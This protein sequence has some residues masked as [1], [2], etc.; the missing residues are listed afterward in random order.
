MPRDLAEQLLPRVAELWNVYG[1]TETTVWSTVYQVTAVT[2]QIPIGHPIANTQIYILDQHMQP[3]PVGV[4]GELY[5]GG[6]GVS[7][8]YL[9]RPQL[10]SERFIP[11]PFSLDPDAR[12]YKTGDAARYLPDGNIIF[13]GRLDFQ[14]K[15]RGFRIELGEI[16]AA[17]D[18][19]TAV[20]QS[21]V[22]VHEENSSEKR[23][24]AYYI[25]IGDQLPTVSDLRRHIQESLPAYMIPSV[26]I[27][28]DSFPLTPNR[29]V[30]RK[31]L[32][33][34]EQSRPQLEA[35]YV[36]P[37]TEVENIVAEA[38][39]NLLKVEKVGIKDNFFD[40]GGHS[41]LATNLLARMAES[42]EVNIPLRSFF[43]MPTIKFL[44]EQIEISKWLHE[45]PL[46]DLKG[47]AEEREEFEL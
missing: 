31:A 20:E 42:F 12:L 44:A 17:L 43:E 26:F 8:G 30:N 23:L 1:P 2:N 39:R 15:V 5:I 19:H 10:T 16:E 7:C 35:E 37:Q 6:S 32:P 9:N 22:I 18:Q 36:A 28:L 29:K 21:V 34:P 33:Q 11:D 4:P 25:P 27:A 40:L 24:V 47:E 13:I 41:L 45:E 38:W 3:V 46:A 14:V